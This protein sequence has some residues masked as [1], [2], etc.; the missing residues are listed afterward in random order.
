M[1]MT[2]PYPTDSDEY[3]DFEI[4]NNGLEIFNDPERRYLGGTRQPHEL[5]Y[6][7]GFHHHAT[8]A[9]IKARI[10][11][12]TDQPVNVTS[13]WLDKTAYVFPSSTGVSTQKRELAD[14]AVVL[15]DQTEKNRAM[16]ILQAKK[17]DIPAGNLPKNVSTK[18]EIELFERSPKFVLKPFSKAKTNLAF[19]LEPEFG[20]P[21]NSANFRHWSFL[22]FRESQTAPPAGVPSP[23]QWRWN[24]SGQNPETGS[25]MTGITEM[26]LPSND[27]NHKGA[28]L[29]GGIPNGWKAL[30]DALMHHVSDT[31]ILGHAGGPMRI[32]TFY[33]NKPLLFWLDSPLH[34]FSLSS[35]VG[36]GL[37]LPKFKF[38]MISTG[39]RQ[40]EASQN[41]D[42]RMPTDYY[43]VEKS[44]TR[45]I[46]RA[47]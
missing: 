11:A 27:P 38:D 31:T 26:M 16:W 19:D 40:I 29:H 1:T 28:M 22:M 37:Q 17:N 8:L 42:D 4:W 32:S 45:S 30:F 44:I 9:A 35:K 21:A 6:L 10:Q 39:S 33:R 41:W 36:F 7:R 43:R 15:S 47:I 24:G 46:A 18:K 2:N 3:V 20:C 5:D 25:F 14:L 23:V 13:F 12:K 34:L